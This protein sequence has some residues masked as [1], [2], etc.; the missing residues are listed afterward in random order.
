[1]ISCLNVPY[2]AATVERRLPTHYP[3]MIEASAG[4]GSVAQIKDKRAGASTVDVAAG[5]ISKTL[6][7]K[8]EDRA[9]V[10]TVQITQ[11]P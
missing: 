3:D 2:F 11:A 5:D 10:I 4:E 6:A 8:A 7:I 9:G 1:M